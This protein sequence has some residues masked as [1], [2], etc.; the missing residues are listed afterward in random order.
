M[1][2]AQAKADGQCETAGV[3]ASAGSDSANGVTGSRTP[4]NQTEAFVDRICHD[5]A[6][7]LGIPQSVKIPKAF[8]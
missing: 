2:A 7:K 4:Q 8:F 1:N 3:K 5:V 6:R